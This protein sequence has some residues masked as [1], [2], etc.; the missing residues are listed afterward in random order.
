M[1]AEA[2]A[3]T[4]KRFYDAFDRCDGETMAACYAPGAHF[5]DP[6]FPDLNGD[7]PGLMWTMLTSRADDLKVELASYDADETTGRANWIPTYTFAK[8]GNHVV[9]DIEAK[10]RFNEQGLI[11]EHI[12]HFDFHKWSRQALGLP[13]L[14]FGWTPFLQK[15]V[16]KQ[17]GAQL[18]QFKADRSG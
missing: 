14:L 13:G 17:A 11:T 12:D 3:A 9:N 6:A 1:T 4:I 2:N 16:Q 8:T 18:E 10:F 15:A 5:E 7:E